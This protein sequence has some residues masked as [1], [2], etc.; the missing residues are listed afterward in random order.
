MW[1]VYSL[2]KKQFQRHLTYSFNMCHDL[3]YVCDIATGVTVAVCVYN[4]YSNVLSHDWFQVW[5][6]SFN[7]WH[8]S[9]YVFYGWHDYVN[10]RHDPM[11]FLQHVRVRLV[12][13][14]TH[15]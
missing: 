9:L 14:M 13:D 5:H 7:S 2:I 3:F 11:C 6:D 12:C 4:T 8:D 10:M 15:S 1:C